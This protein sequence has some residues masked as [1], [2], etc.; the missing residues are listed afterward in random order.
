MIHESQS[1]PQTP[2]NKALSAS[3]KESNLGS[4]VSPPLHNF[5]VGPLV[6][7]QTDVLESVADEDAPMKVVHGEAIESRLTEIMP[8]TPVIPTGFRTAHATL[9]SNLQGLMNSEPCGEYCVWLS[10]EA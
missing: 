7:T 10:A 3:K 2:Q 8:G 5:Q 1:V 6:T 4:L 9:R